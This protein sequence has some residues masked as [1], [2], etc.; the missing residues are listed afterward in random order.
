MSSDFSLLRWGANT[1]G[2]DAQLQRVPKL[3]YVLLSMESMIQVC[4]ALHV[5]LSMVLM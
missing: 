1:W 5:R 3:H 2:F 4:S